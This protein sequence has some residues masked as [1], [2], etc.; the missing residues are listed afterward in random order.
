MAD[1]ADEL[2]GVINYLAGLEDGLKLGALI[3][4]HKVFIQV[5]SCGGQ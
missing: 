5:Q 2:D 4:V 1:V 3:L